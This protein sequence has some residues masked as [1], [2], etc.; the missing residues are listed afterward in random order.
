MDSWDYN[1]LGSILRYYTSGSGSS[2][3][4]VCWNS[5]KLFTNGASGQ[6]N[7]TSGI[8]WSINIAN[9]YPA[10]TPTS[11]GTISVSDKATGEGVILLR[12]APTAIAYTSSG[13]QVTAGINI[14]TGALLWGPLNQSIPQ[15][16]DVTMVAS[17]ENVFILHNKDTNEAYGYSLNSGLQI[18]GPVKLS[19]NAF[20]YLSRGAEIAYGQVYIWDFGG[21]VH[22]LDLQTGKINWV[23]TRGSAG[24]D[25]P[26][27]IWP[28]WH[29]GSQSM[30]DGMLFLSESRMYDPPMSPGYHRLAINC[31]TG[32]L[33]WKIESFSGRAPGAIADGM[34]VQWNSYD[35]QLDVFG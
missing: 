23:F 29:F 13:Y 14:K 31:T 18:W 19:G 10:G 26:Y 25:N 9:T 17:G 21:F 16:Q 7:W 30:G 3:E 32:E 28:I 34:M 24:Y 6:R 2:T 20:S 35:K 11:I 22:A 8:E 12:S 27:G 1:T 15:Y 4:L 33:V 5:S